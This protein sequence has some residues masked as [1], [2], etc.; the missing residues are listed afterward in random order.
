MFEHWNDPLFCFSSHLMWSHLSQ[1]K[2]CH[3]G[4]MSQFIWKP[5]LHVLNK[6]NCGNKIRRKWQNMAS[7]PPNEQK[8]SFNKFYLVV[9]Y[10]FR[11]YLESW[12]VSKPT[13]NSKFGATLFCK[14]LKV[15]IKP[16]PDSQNFITRACTNT[17]IWWCSFVWCRC[18]ICVCRC[19][20]LENQPIWHFC[21]LTK[22]ISNR[23]R[24]QLVWPSWGQHFNF[25]P[26]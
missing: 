8:D 23:L 22:P 26:K 13:T 12:L 25:S 4:H 16:L 24:H 19:N 7:C 15:I 10:S 1:Q 6:M 9:G 18:L 2:L 11:N 17:A 20:S 3:N 21:D 14:L 5:K